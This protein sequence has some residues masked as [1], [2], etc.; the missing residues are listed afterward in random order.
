MEIDVLKDLKH[1]FTVN[2]GDGAF[3]GFA[4]G[5]ASFVTIIPLFVSTMTHS[6]LLIGLIPA[7]HTAGW[8]LPQL[9]TAGWIAR[10]RW[11]RPMVLALTI[12]ERLPF[13]GLALVAGFMTSLGKPLALAITFLLLIWQ[14][15]GA[16]LTANPWMVMVG[17]IIPSDRR[18]T[19]F[20]AQAAAANLLSS[21]SAF[22]AGVALE[23]LSSPQ[24]FILCFILCSVSMIISWWFLF[25]TREHAS[26]P[27]EGVATVSPITRQF[28]GRMRTILHSDQNFR[29][30]LVARAISQL[31]AMGFAFYTVYAVNEQGVSEIGVGAMTTTLLIAQVLG[32][33]LM[34]W[35]S[36]RWSRKGVMEIGLLAAALS[37][38]LAWWAPSPGWFFLVYALA[39]VGNVAIWTIGIAMSLEFGSE[40]DRPAYIGLSNTL[41]APVAILAPFLGGWL[42]G[43][44]GYPATFLASAVGALVATLVFLLFVREGELQRW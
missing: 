14:G 4:M 24:D 16:G 23:R 38:L 36:D 13:L 43:W 30:F 44:A 35:M 3:F 18:T 12:Q 17:K 25:M 41:L 34:G 26:P 10:Q 11:V 6:P 22:L 5:F 1:N 19:F 7:I 21:L 28:W 37:A 40:S 8:Q 27:A 29:W 39:A 9:F 15:L 20:G 2:I 33:V 32:N 31:A 42:A